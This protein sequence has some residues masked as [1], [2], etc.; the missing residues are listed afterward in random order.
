[1]CANGGQD[2][3]RAKSIG[4]L[5][6][7]LHLTLFPQGNASER[8]ARAT[9]TQSIR[10]QLPKICGNFARQI[11]DNNDEKYKPMKTTTKT[12]CLFFALLALACFALSPTAQAVCQQ[13]CD[14]IANTFLGDDA[15]SNNTNGYSNTAIGADTLQ[16]NTLGHGNTATGWSAL[17]QNTTGRDNTA[18]GT[19]A[20][21][22]NT[23]G[24]RNTANGESALF[25]NVTGTNNTAIG[26]SAL[27]FTTGPGNVGVGSEAGA[28]LTTGNGNV[29]L[30]AFVHGNA[31][32]SNT[33]RIRNVYSSVASD[34]AVYVTADNKIGTL[35]S[36]RR[37][38]EEIRPMDKASEAILALNPVTFRYKKEIESNGSI[39]FGLIAEDVE[40]AD[41]DLVTRNEKG[42]AET[43]RYEAVNAM[44]LNEFL[45]EHETVQELKKQVAELTAGLQKVTAQLE[46]SKS[47]PQTVSN[48]H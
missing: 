19:S 2:C 10:K 13:G 42:E 33:T 30:G 43:V 8:F 6:K 15:L 38:K 5:L 29:C 12:T 28:A 1:M 39:M 41:P 11:P 21:Y 48:N 22:S 37:F 9:E 27:Y 47:A 32:E 4:R 36:S 24:Y 7:E 31:G 3:I 26:W 25:E 23:T 17:T 16:A 45:K 34:R 35:V 46:L 18:T 20:L 40:K 44:L 14:T